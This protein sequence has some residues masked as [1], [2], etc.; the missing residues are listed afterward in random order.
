MVNRGL[1]LVKDISKMSRN[2]TYFT[3]IYQFSS[4]ESCFLQRFLSIFSIL[5]FKCT[6]VG[7]L[8]KIANEP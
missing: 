6:P 2:V 5:L 3:Q 8:L 1:Q 4:E 7:T